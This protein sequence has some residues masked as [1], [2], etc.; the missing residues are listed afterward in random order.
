MQPTLKAAFLLRTQIACIYSHAIL[1]R[2]ADRCT[3]LRGQ[4]RQIT[5]DWCRA[6]SRVTYQALYSQVPDLP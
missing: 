4:T 5:F 1:D 2:P 6:D 3:H